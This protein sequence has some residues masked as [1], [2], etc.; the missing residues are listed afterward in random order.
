MSRTFREVTEQLEREMSDEDEC[1]KCECGF[2]AIQAIVKKQ[3]KNFGKQYFGC[4]NWKDGGCKF[5]E[6]ADAK[7]KKAPG[8]PTK[9]KFQEFKQAASELV[10]SCRSPSKTEEVETPAWNSDDDNDTLH[11][12]K[13]V[14]KLTEENRARD[15]AIELMKTRLEELESKQLKKL[16]SIESILHKIVENKH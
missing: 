16:E 3:G 4:S 7:P 9:R 11:L 15:T 2:P 1:V 10:N 13:K 8:A 14:Q 6:W 5:F 12:Q